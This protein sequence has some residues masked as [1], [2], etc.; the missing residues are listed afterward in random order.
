ME[1]GDAGTDRIAGRPEA[2]E[3]LAR[4]EAVLD[5]L[6][7]AVVAWDVD[8]TILCWNAS[9]AR[10]YG[11]AAEE[12]LGTYIGDLLILPDDLDAARAIGLLVEAGTT[13]EGDV[14]IVRA[15]GTPV[16]IHTVIR[17]LA[18][19]DG[20]V[21]GSIASADDVTVQRAVEQRAAEQTNHLLMALASGELGTW[22]RDFVTGTVMWDSSMERLFGLEPGAFDGTVESWFAMLHPDDRQRVADVIDHALDHEDGYAVEYR[23]VHPDRS[24]H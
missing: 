24:V 4:T 14:T 9:A 21:V 6:P 16:R 8:A 20:R 15:D 19:E 12:V 5:A 3:V 1:V 13:W 23:V 22:R 18:N 7:R 10:L 11:W 2:L 17:P